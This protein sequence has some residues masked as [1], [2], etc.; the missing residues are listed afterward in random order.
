MWH[1]NRYPGARVDSEVPYYQFTVREVWKDW[2]W[3][4]RF[5]G[6]EELRRYFEH[7]AKT[8]DLN[9]HIQF[10]TIVVEC[11]F[12]ETNKRW[13][14][15]T[16]SGREVSR[17]YLI[18]A[19]GSSYKQHYPEFPGIEDYKGVLLHSADFPGEGHYFKGESTAVIGQGMW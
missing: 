2:N 1:W 6:H 13:S 17:R 16:A 3:S 5:P 10:E 7:A 14:V 18:V 8:L 15:K 9:D 11:N 12:D 4:E 19:A